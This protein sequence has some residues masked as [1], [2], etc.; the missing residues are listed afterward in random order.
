MYLSGV[1]YKNCVRCKIQLWCSLPGRS[2]WYGLSFTPPI[3]CPS[4]FHNT[5]SFW[6]IQISLPTSVSRVNFD[7]WNS[8]TVVRTTAY[9]YDIDSATEP[10]YHKYEVLMHESLN[11]ILSTTLF[12]SNRRTNFTTFDKHQELYD[13]F[14]WLMVYFTLER[15][16]RLGITVLTT[17]D[18]TE[19]HCNKNSFYELY[20]IKV[21]KT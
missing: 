10:K 2:K 4:R 14:I 1:V 12:I 3:V 8:T 19:S 16:T 21:Q 15:H 13:L 6:H 17:R 11:T 9:A 5:N 20:S 7:S 18:Y